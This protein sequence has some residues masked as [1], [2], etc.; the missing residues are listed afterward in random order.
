VAIVAAINVVGFAAAMTVWRVVEGGRLPPLVYVLVAAFGIVE[1]VPLY[2]RRVR[3]LPVLLVV[4]L[5]NFAA[6]ATVALGGGK[7]EAASGA[8]VGGIVALYAVGAYASRRDAWIGLGAGVAAIALLEPLTAEPTESVLAVVVGMALATGFGAVLPWV[9]GYLVRA[10]RGLAAE[11]ATTARRTRDLEAERA[12]RAV[13]EER[14]R[15]ARDLH[16]VIAHHVGVMVIQAGAGQRVLHRDPERAMASFRAIQEAGKAALNAMPAVLGA[17]RGDGRPGLAPVPTLGDVDALVEQVEAAGLTVRR[18]VGG[19]PRPLPPDV[20][21]AAYR[22]LQ[23]ALTNVLKHAGPV[24]ATVSVTYGA[25]LLEVAVRDAGPVGVP[26]AP[27]VSVSDGHG[28]VGMRERVE[29]LGGM[30]RAGPLPGGGFEVVVWLPLV[31]ERAPV[32]EARP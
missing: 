11:R 7:V 25:D 6:H 3:P 29:L 17:L 28:L 1:A 2:W 22:V 9:V 20:E 16:D 32:A 8:G 18:E 27:V 13:A 26:P 23:E 4:L 12:R 5:V 15:I 10:N 19:E 24:P 30:L 21:L 31:G 14:S